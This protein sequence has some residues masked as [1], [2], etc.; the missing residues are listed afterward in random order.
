M[1][2]SKVN[3]VDAMFTAQ[4]LTAIWKGSTGIA[5]YVAIAAVI[6]IAG[7]FAFITYKKSL[8][9]FPE[10][11]EEEPEEPLEPELSDSTGDP[12]LD[13]ILKLAGYAYDATQD[14]FYSRMYPWQ[15]DMGYCR[16]YDEAAAPMSLI[17]DC[18]PIYFDY[19]GKRWMIE[20]WKGQYGMTSGGEIGVYNTDKPDIDIPELFTGTFFDCASDEERLH[21]S[22]TLVKNG[23][24]MFSR[25]GKHWWLTGFKLGEFSQP[26][27]LVMYI[28]IALKDRIM[29][30][31]FIG[32]LLKAGYN[33][34][35]IYIEDNI[36]GLVFDKPRTQQPFTR[37][38]ETDCITQK[39]NELLCK[40]YMEITAEYPTFP[41]K[42]RAIREKAPGIYDAIIDI[43]KTR[44]I[45]AAY[46]KLRKFLR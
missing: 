41:E 19:A 11:T 23:E 1:V 25:R 16:L 4:V 6:L 8:R 7:I 9:K 33:R 13:E 15:R 28:F 29:R 46:E 26:S 38:E 42:I 43:G 18:E 44:K 45:F 30:D 39:K 5:L 27:E 3:G 10:E 24:I 14:I 32:G 20:F 21:M 40:A 12:E 22:F 36:V 34:D 2:Q 37:I 35:E 17:M 31:A